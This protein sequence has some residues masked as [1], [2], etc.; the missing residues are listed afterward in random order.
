MVVWLKPCKSRSSPRASKTTPAVKGGGFLLPRHP[1]SSSHTI[2]AARHPACRSTPRAALGQVRTAIFLPLPRCHRSSRAPPSTSLPR[3]RA[4]AQCAALRPVHAEI[5]AHQSVPLL[6]LTRHLDWPS[7]A[8]DAP[9]DCPADC[10]L[11]TSSSLILSLA[12]QW[13]GSTHQSRVKPRQTP[14]VVLRS[15]W[16][17]RPSRSVR[18]GAR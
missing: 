1:A 3:A 10:I 18:S 14:E 11:S 6:V 15:K 13:G 2:A 7:R 12:R 16:H 17:A 8:A 5:R 4:A 9:T